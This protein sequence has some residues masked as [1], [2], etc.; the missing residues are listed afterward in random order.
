MPTKRASGPSLSVLPVVDRFDGKEESIAPVQD[1]AGRV[2]GVGWAELFNSHLES[3][4]LRSDWVSVHSLHRGIDTV[5]VGSAYIGC[6][7]LTGDELPI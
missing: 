6:H 2:V 1:Q 5:K 7:S 3:C 4:L